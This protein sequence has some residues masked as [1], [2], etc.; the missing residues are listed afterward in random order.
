MSLNCLV[1]KIVPG[2]FISIPLEDMKFM[3][4]QGPTDRINLNCSDNIPVK[5]NKT[6]NISFFGYLEINIK[7]EL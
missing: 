7:A 6:D 2:H 5:N 3:M 4:K 1:Q